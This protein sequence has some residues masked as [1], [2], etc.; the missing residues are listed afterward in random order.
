MNW[1]SEEEKT[2]LQRTMKGEAKQEEYGVCT[3]NG[4]RIEGLKGMYL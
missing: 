4:R 3:W 1:R 2:L